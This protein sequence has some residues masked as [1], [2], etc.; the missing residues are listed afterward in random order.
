MVLLL[1][2]GPS[3]GNLS[4][5]VVTILFKISASQKNHILKAYMWNLEKCTDEPISSA[6]TE[7]QMYRRDMRTRGGGQGRGGTNWESGSDVYARPWVK[8]KASAE[9]LPAQEAQLSTL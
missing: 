3:W 4:S 5:L 6:G 1:G 7:M 8:Q 2:S 9:Q